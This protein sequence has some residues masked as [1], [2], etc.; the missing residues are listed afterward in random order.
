M[1]LSYRVDVQ[2][3]TSQV[4]TPAP[5][6]GQ[7][8]TAIG[9]KAYMIGGINSSLCGDIVKVTNIGDEMRWETLSLKCLTPY[10]P[11]QSHTSV[12]WK[13]KVYS[14]GGSYMFNYSRRLR[15]C[16]N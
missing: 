2:K 16:S 6:E 3:V 13:G 4:W 15:E 7:T 14:F 10:Q 11:V 8:L 9:M 5:R 12:D 1:L